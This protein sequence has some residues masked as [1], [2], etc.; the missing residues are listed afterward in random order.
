MIQSEG[1]V[2]PTFDRLEPSDYSRS[3]GHQLEFRFVTA[4]RC[5][6]LVEKRYIGVLAQRL[7]RADG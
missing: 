4:I 7:I 1:T 3:F 5:N 2:A 6:L